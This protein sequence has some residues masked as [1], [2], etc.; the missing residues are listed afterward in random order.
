M[1]CLYSRWNFI[2]KLFRLDDARLNHRT[3]LYVIVLTRHNTQA[4]HLLGHRIGCWPSRPRQSMQRPRFRGNALSLF[5][6]LDYTRPYRGI[7]AAG[8][9]CAL[10]NT[11]RILSLRAL[12]FPFQL[13]N[14]SQSTQ[15][16]R[17]NFI[18]C[19]CFCCSAI[20]LLGCGNSN[21]T[22]EVEDVAIICF[23]GYNTP[24]SLS[25]FVHPLFHP[26]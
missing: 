12:P 4:A 6:H 9:L 2:E 18:S 5:C 21:G 22:E 25:V 14:N 15:T 19:G 3:H 7:L 1:S 26:T 16:Y 13:L 20:F 11:L 23:V 17:T 24:Y 8:Y 10:L